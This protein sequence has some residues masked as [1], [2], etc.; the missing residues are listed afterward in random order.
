MKPLKGK[1]A[2]QLK[3]VPCEKSGEKFHFKGGRKRAGNT[4]Y[5]AGPLIFDILATSFPHP[6]PGSPLRN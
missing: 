2:G 5:G 4:E 6:L 3:K 1:V